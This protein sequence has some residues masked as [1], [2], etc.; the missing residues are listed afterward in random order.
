VY[1]I[2]VSRKMG[3]FRDDEGALCWYILGRSKHGKWC[4]EAISVVWE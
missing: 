4:A 3:I 1:F 2:P